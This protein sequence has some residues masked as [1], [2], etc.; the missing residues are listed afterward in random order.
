M[1]KERSCCVHFSSIDCKNETLVQASDASVA[2]IIKFRKRWSLLDGEACV[3]ARESQQNFSDAEAE[4]RCDIWYHRKCYQKFTNKRT[5]EMAGR[6][7]LKCEQSRKEAEPP[8][9]TRQTMPL[10]LVPSLSRSSE[11]SST[12][13]RSGSSR[14]S[15]SILPEVCIICKKKEHYYTDKVG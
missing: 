2:A 3:V 7:L 15:A 14:R 9:K 12:A 6:R 10:G 8:R 11:T 1:N 4:Q 5:L 13:S